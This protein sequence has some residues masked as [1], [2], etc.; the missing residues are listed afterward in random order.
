MWCGECCKPKNIRGDDQLVG[1]K[2]LEKFQNG[3]D[4]MRE[5]RG[6]GWQCK[7]GGGERRTNGMN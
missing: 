4:K 7:F 2:K 1:N 5:K 3:M 6:G